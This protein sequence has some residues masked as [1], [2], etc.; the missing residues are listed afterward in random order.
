[1]HP[2]P[3]NNLSTRQILPP[4]ARTATTTSSSV[5]RVASGAAFQDA[6]IVISTGAITDGTHTVDVQE[7]ADNSTWTSAAATDLQG[8][9]PVIGAADDNKI[10]EIGYLGSLRYVR[11]VVTAAG[12]T[13]GGIY[14]IDVVLAN[15]RRAAVVHS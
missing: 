11:V 2:N 13:T 5:D 8:P 15:P 4:A 9:E 1:M 6:V 12:T 7:S 14:G 3:Y 10:F